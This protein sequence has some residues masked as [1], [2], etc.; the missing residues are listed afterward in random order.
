MHQLL[1]TLFRDECLR[2]KN[3]NVKLAIA[4]SDFNIHRVLQNLSVVAPTL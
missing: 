1:R 3:T 4:Y 2:S